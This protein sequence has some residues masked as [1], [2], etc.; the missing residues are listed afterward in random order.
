M[1]LWSFSYPDQCMIAAL[2]ALDNYRNHCPYPITTVTCMLSFFFPFLPLLFLLPITSFSLLSSLSF[3]YLSSS[4]YFLSHIP[5]SPP[6]FSFSWSPHLFFSAIIFF[7]FCTGSLFMR[8][9]GGHRSG[10]SVTRQCHKLD[11]SVN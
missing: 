8:V 1:I 9:D 11:G 10:V 3:P 7:S 2:F 4:P 5:P 6:L